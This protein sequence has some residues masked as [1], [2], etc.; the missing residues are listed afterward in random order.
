[1]GTTTAF[2]ANVNFFSQKQFSLAIIDEASQIL[3]PHLIG[4][5]SACTNDGLPAIRKFI[6]IGDHKQLP[7][8]VQQKEE[9]SKVDDPLL[10]GIGLTNCRLSLFERL[11]K[12]YRHDP[13]VVYM[14]THQ[15]RM[16]HDIAAFPNHEFY[17]D[18][19]QEVPLPHQTRQLPTPRVAFV[20]IEPPRQTTSDKVNTNEAQAIAATVASIYKQTEQF[21]PTFT[22]GVIVPYRNQIAEVRRALEQTGIAQLRDITI[23]TVERFQ[24]SQRQYI[25]YGFTVQH[26]YQLN[27]LT[28]NTF[29]E[30]GSII[31]RKLNVAMTRARE[32]LILF[33]NPR[34]LESNTT[35]ARLI[36]FTRKHKA[37]FAP[38][39]DDYLSSLFK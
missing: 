14:L 1:V 11:L 17:H 39:V 37:F 12:R 27:F 18:K 34:L 35:F 38:P 33:G 32:G 13:S 7:A 3:E 31:D 10:N 28:S 20:A 15:G 2:N 19:L 16:H 21:D 36:A 4:I 9:E 24:G 25:L 30:D 6:F 22:V 29:E 23:D 8:V 5:L 26:P